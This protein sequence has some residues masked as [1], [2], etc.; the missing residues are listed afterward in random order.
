MENRAR[1]HTAGYAVLPPP[2]SVNLY[3][4]GVM[5]NTYRVRGLISQAHTS[6]ELTLVTQRPIACVPSVYPTLSLMR[7]GD[8]EC[9]ALDSEAE[10]GHV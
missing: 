3:G 10:V 7:Y 4:Y 9:H 1:A 5:L 2:R 8:G 6:Q